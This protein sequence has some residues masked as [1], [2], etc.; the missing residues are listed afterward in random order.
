MEWQKILADTA[1]IQ[2]IDRVDEIVEHYKKEKRERYRSPYDVHPLYPFYGDAPL[3]FMAK[4]DLSSKLSH[5]RTQLATRFSS[6][7]QQVLLDSD[8]LN[9]IIPAVILLYVLELRLHVIGILV[10]PP[11]HTSSD[12][13]TKRQGVENY[14]I[15][16][17]GHITLITKS[18]DVENYS[19]DDTGHITLI[20][21][22]IGVANYTHRIDITENRTLNSNS[23]ISLATYANLIILNTSP[24]YDSINEY[25]RPTSPL[26]ITQQMISRRQKLMDM[27][28]KNI[29]QQ[30]ESI[31]ED[32]IVA[33]EYD[34][35][36][37]YYKQIDHLTNA[38]SAVSTYGY[39]NSCLVNIVI[40]I[41][42]MTCLLSFVGLINSF[43]PQYNRGINYP[44]WFPMVIIAL[45]L[46]IPYILFRG[47]RRWQHSDEY[48]AAQLLK[49]NTER[50]EA[51]IQRYNR[52]RAKF[53]DIENGRKMQHD[54]QT[55]IND[56]F[57]GVTKRT[58]G[59][60][61]PIAS[62][63]TSKIVVKDNNLGCH[64]Q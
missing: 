35:Y 32:I 59:S 62:E 41:L 42:G 17:T 8:N 10:I 3:D 28:D 46:I 29:H 25:L 4:M 20:Y 61:I 55:R 34:L 9:S 52:L 45:H 30:I 16:D 19:I 50:N 37:T 53:K 33:S 11:T 39:R 40:S 1:P 18:L 6:A 47:I 43:T 5:L 57:E 31:V 56:Y 44:F 22:K 12:N 58:M 51:I 48:K 54:A 38:E 36:L 2:Y 24:L 23:T 7:I 14:S 21:T 63:A 49:K 64:P 26:H 27:I 15:D 13:S 60:D